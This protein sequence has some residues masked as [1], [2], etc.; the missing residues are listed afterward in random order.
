MEQLTSI[1]IGAGQCGLAMSR[2]LSARSV[3]HLI[4]ER[5]GVANSWRTER[6]D[7]LR[8]LTPNW[9]GGLPDA[10]YR[11]PDPD[12]F[13][14]MPEVIGRLSG[15]AREI[16]APVRGG[17]S[18]HRVAPMGDGYV[19]ETDHGPFACRNLVMA[20]GA[21]NLPAVPGCAGDVPGGVQM[22]T[23]FDY[24]RPADLPDGRVLVVGGSATGVQL[25]REIQLSG[26]QVILSV[27]EHVRVPR[28]YRGR[29]IKWW[30][31]ALGL[32]GQRIEDVDDVAR[33]RRTPSLQL[34]GLPEDVDLNALSGIGVEV[35]GRLAGIR[36]GK[37]VFSGA[38]ANHC[39][40]A[41]LKL[42]RLL[43]LIDDLAR[44]RGLDAM[45]PPADRPA[46][47]RI[48]SRPRLEVGLS[49]GT[50]SA[51][52]WATGF[53]PDH[54]W[55]DMPVFD[56]RGR[57]AHDRGVVAPGLYAMGLP[58]MRRRNSTLIGGAGDDARELA[59]HMMARL[60]RAAA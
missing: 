17:V 11:G 32:I 15:Y 5:G 34:A 8:L 20:T 41:D 56:R 36:D 39:A 21:C 48:P 16:K 59:A 24:K 55:L 40:M 26:R 28:R 18:V 4:L 33:V 25:A 42:N 30:L 38:L 47:T 54:S 58:F 46:P 2:H 37:A 43:G 23:P 52:V 45:L 13:M 50:I 10:P 12:G 14:S 57:L 9:M 60:D 1:I 6:W 7:A 3:D 29:D 35:V 19:V 49:D 44:S 53:R 31:D 51:I 22:L 27:G